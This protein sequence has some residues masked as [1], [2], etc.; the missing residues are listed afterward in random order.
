MK[1]R[2]NKTLRSTEWLQ[3]EQKTFRFWSDCS[4]TKCRTLMYSIL[5][6]VLG[7]VFLTNFGL[8]CVVQIRCVQYVEN[9]QHKVRQVFTSYLCMACHE[10]QWKPRFMRKYFRDC[11]NRSPEVPCSPPK[12]KSSGSRDA[13]RCL[14]TPSPRQITYVVSGRSIFIKAFPV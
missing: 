7:D 10:P 11:P 4:P 2:L 9:E 3:I 14:G 6:A 12:R 13:H 5:S 8:R 1:N